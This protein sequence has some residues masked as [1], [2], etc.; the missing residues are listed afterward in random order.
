VKP[1]LAKAIFTDVQFW[2]PLA[3]LAAGIGILLAVR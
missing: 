3:V 2:L 1:P